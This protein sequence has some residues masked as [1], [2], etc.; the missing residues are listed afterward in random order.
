MKKEEQVAEKKGMAVRGSVG[1]CCYDDGQERGHL[2]GD[3]WSNVA[4][5]R[6]R[7]AGGGLG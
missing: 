5:G 3:R 6:T 1:P 7:T 2:W 4:A